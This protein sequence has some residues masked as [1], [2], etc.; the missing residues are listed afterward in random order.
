MLFSTIADN[1]CI[2]AI[3]WK[4][5]FKLEHNIVKADQMNLLEAIE[6]VDMNDIIDRMN[7]Y[8]MYR[9]RS[10]GIKDFN[11]KQPVDFVGDLIL[12]VMEGQRDWSKASCPFTEFLFGCLRSDIDSF[13]KTRKSNYTN[14]L[15]ELKTI[16][17][18]ANINEQRKQIYTFLEQEEADDD[19]LLVFECW[20]EGLTKPSEIAKELGVDVK[21]VYN[22]TKRLTRR[23]PKIIPK[24]KIVL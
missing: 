2:F 14:E 21:V 3:N 20:A 13:F 18:S 10:V 8:A 22:I 6:S 15:P 16:D 19:E 24:V 7:A 23:I 9:L 12:K 4:F 5:F 11:G 17:A 1:H